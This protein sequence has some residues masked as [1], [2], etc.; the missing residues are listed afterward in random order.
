[1]EGWAAVITQSTSRGRPMVLTDQQPQ[2]RRM[3]LA[4]NSPVRKDGAL[5]PHHSRRP[6]REGITTSVP[7]THIL[8]HL[9]LLPWFW[10]SHVRRVTAPLLQAT[11]KSSACFLPL[12]AA[13]LYNTARSVRLLDCRLDLRIRREALTERGRPATRRVPRRQ[14]PFCS[15]P[16]PSPWCLT[17]AIE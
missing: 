6:L 1:M 17:S 2:F 11:T 15:P 10:S 5:L 12:F 16:Q 13:P 9:S 3:Q 7:R 4:T 8:T 14:S